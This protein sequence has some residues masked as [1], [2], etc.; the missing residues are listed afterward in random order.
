VAQRGQGRANQCNRGENTHGELV[1]FQRTDIYDRH[2]RQGK[3]ARRSAGPEGI[4]TIST[5]NCRDGLRHLF[6]G[7]TTQPPLFPTP[8]SVF[9]GKIK[10]P[11]LALLQFVS[12]FALEAAGG[13]FAGWCGFA[14]GAS[15]RSCVFERAHGGFGRSFEIVFLRLGLRHHPHNHDIVGARVN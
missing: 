8:N 1:H 7:D 10:K 13:G 4:Q 14:T 9:R 6:V 11:A 15:G 2:R 5:Y 3:W 12:R